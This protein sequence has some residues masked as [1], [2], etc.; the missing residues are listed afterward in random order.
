VIEIR[1]G[2]A[3]INN[4]TMNVVASAGHNQIIAGTFLSTYDDY[5]LLNGTRYVNHRG[6]LKKK[7]AVSTLTVVNVTLFRE[8]LSLPFLHDLTIK[9]LCHIGDLRTGLS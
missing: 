4:A 6:I 7:P 5:V 1:E 3:V 8:H 2:I 9:N